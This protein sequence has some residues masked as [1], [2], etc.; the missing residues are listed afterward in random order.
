MSAEPAA[1]PRDRSSTAIGTTRFDFQHKVFSVPDAHFRLDRVRGMVEFRLSLGG[2]L[3]SVPL[4]SLCQTFDI[5]SDSDDAKLLR[6]V[7]K[8]LK[9][10]KEI[11]PGDSIPNE[12]LDGT[13]SWKIDSQHHDMARSRL[14]VQLVAWLTGSQSGLADASEALVAIEQPEIK[15]KINTAFEEAAA[16]LGFGKDGKQKITDM[17]DQLARE[18]AYIEA[19]REKIGGFL[20]IEKKLKMLAYNFRG[21]RSIGESIIRIQTLTGPPLNA[22]RQRF[23]MVDGQTTEIIAALKKLGTTIDFVRATRDH[24]REAVLL[25]EDIAE[26]WTDASL[27]RGEQSEQ[28]IA[29]TYRFAATNFAVGQRWTLNV[30]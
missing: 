8:G 6:M 18:M 9:F 21:D 2:M 30:G 26:S 25:W 3:A 19:L 12:V 11:R 23:T 15:E 28:L 1:K 24:L 29:Q 14:I 7:E 22:L 5:A 4:N 16:K 20:G 10:V 17:I 13:A 27:E